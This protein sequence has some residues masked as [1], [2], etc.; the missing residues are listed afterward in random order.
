MQYNDVC[1]LLQHLWRTFV[2]GLRKRK[3]I[4]RRLFCPDLLGGFKK[5][6]SDHRTCISVGLEESAPTPVML[7]VDG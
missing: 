6:K 7:D 2:T 4:E 3:C 1:M 5:K